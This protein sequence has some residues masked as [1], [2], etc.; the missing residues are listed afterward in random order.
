[1]IIN[2]LESKKLNSKFEVSFSYRWTLAYKKG[3]EKRTSRHNHIYPLKLPIA[4]ASKPKS[5]RRDFLGFRSVRYFWYLV[6]FPIIFVVNIILLRNLFKRITPDILHINNGG[7]PGATSC[8]AAV[9]AGRLSNVNKITFV[10]N[11]MA[12]DYHNPYRWLDIVIDFFISKNVTKFITGSIEA[13]N[14]LVQVL[15]LDSRNVI[16]IPNGVNS[17]NPTESKMQIRK[18]LG[19]NDQVELIFGMVGVMEYRK[20]HH[21]LLEAIQ[22]LIMQTEINQSK[23]VILI[24]GSGGISNSLKDFV[25]INNLS[26]VV[27]FI[28]AEDEIF[29]FYELIDVLIYPAIVDEDFPNVISEAMSMRKPVVSSNVAGANL[30]ILPGVSGVLIPR[31]SKNHLTKAIQEIIENPEVAK[32]MGTESLKRYKEN[33]TAEIAVDRYI[34]FFDTVLGT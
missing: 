4:N 7:Y 18:R 26:T 31:N 8:R 5:D 11:N 20:G 17:R 15:K 34:E 19:V 9:I 2:F 22:Q 6:S 27:K 25:N 32:I 12:T 30:Q 21:Q 24:E 29:N 3:L 23:F 28:G 1:M 33:F 10:V 13:K 16:N 14:R